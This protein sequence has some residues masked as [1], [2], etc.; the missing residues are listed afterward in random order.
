[1]AWTINFIT[2]QALFYLYYMEGMKALKKETRAKRK[3]RLE[4]GDL[5]A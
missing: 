3:K 1:M 2:S 5:A 4:I